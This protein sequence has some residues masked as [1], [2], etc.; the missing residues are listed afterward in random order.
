ML[1]AIVGFE[2]EIQAWRPTFK[3]GQKDTAADREGA[4]AGLEAQGSPAIAQLMR[5]LAR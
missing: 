3:L 1:K 5:D 4:I 2:L